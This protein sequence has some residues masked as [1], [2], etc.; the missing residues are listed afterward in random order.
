MRYPE[1]GNRPS[2]PRDPQPRIHHPQLQADAGTRLSRASDARARKGWRSGSPNAVKQR[3]AAWP[4][5]L[6]WA[7]RA[8]CC[9]VTMWRLNV[10]RPARK[11]RGMVMEV[12][13]RFVIVV[14]DGQKAIGIAGGVRV[15]ADDLSLAIDPVEPRR[16][17]RVRIVKRG[18]C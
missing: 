1:S 17:G 14:W 18:E 2:R 4:L 3:N 9:Q 13:N 5:C 16:A 10:Q 15:E 8:R 7:R 11:V 12:V 6:R